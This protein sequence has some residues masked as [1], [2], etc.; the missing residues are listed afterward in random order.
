MRIS[1]YYPMQGHDDRSKQAIIIIHLRDNL[2]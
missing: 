2:L 1:I